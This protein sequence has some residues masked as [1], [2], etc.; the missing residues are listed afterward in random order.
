MW[1]YS[2]DLNFIWLNEVVGYEQWLIAM[3]N[4][5]VPRELLCSDHD[6]ITTCPV[7]RFA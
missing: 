3:A 4:P 6:H 5:G 7:R 2:V 1:L